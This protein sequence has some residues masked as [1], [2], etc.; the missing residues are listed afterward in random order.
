MTST[1][2]HTK[3]SFWQWLV[4]HKLDVLIVSLLMLVTG[5]VSAVNMNGYPQ[6]FED[7]GTYIS[8]AWAIKDKGSLTH[9]TYWYDHPPL[10]WIQMA[11]HLQF[12]DAL[13]RHPSAIHAGREFMLLLHIATVGLL[14]A[15][16]RR[17]HISHLAAGI[18]VLAYALSP[19]VVEFS[20]YVLLDN[21]GLPWL[22]AAFVLAL[23][24][25]RSF[26]AAIGSAIC[27]AVAVLSK[28]T[29]AVLLPVLLYSLWRSGDS[30]NRRYVL[31]AFGVVFTMI[32]GSYILYAALKNEL[33]PGQGHVSLIGSLLWQIFGREG[34]GSIFDASSSTR[35]IVNYWL[36]IDYWLLAAGAIGMLPALFMK[37]ARPAALALLISF[38]M[39]LRSGYLPYPYIIAVLPFAALCF[40]ALID[41]FAMRAFTEKGFLHGS[42]LRQMGAV[43]VIA[44]LATVVITSVAPSWQTK[45]AAQ[46]SSDDD[47]SSRE[48]VAWIQ[49]NVPKSKRA[50][51]ESA[52]WT[53][54]QINGFNQPNPVWLYKTETDPTVRQEVGGWQ[55]I[56]YVILNGPTIWDKNFKHAFPTAQEAIEHGTVEATFG[57]GKQTVFVYKINHE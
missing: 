3:R 23:S 1:Q 5:V 4:S 8:Q 40:A 32:S 48:A 25:R 30:R 12:S 55:G 35:G 39:L 53:D 29:L 36:N 19:L 15:L 11:A 38:A 7:E 24:P 22:L 20:R 44:L 31:T 14:Y 18:G 16:A 26:G 43:A 21:V 17:M 45:L 46:S 27:M 37:H 42:L 10:G 33:L 9:Y 41:R 52:I 6:R 50:I 49:Q 47:R 51:V 54:L 13:D 57:S 34:S 28:E 56:D 2:L